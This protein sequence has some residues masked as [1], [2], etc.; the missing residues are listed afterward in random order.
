MA[1]K[2]PRFV[3]PIGEAK[4][5]WLHKPKAGFA[6]DPNKDPKF[7]I[8]LV[9]DP[10]EPA[11]AKWGV[12][13]RQMS[14]GLKLPIKKEMDDHEQPTGRLFVTFKTGEKYPPGVFDKYN[15]PIPESVLVGNGS[16]VRVA[17]TVNQYDGFGGGINLYLSGV[18][19]VDLVEYKGRGAEGYGFTAEPMPAGAPPGMMAPPQTQ[20]DDLPF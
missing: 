10:K 12:D 13:L 14:N 17:Y 1:E 11:W 6:G 18:Q 2:K 3:T 4:W 20:E 7:M 15:Q 5:A 19:V 8:D 9:F 16:K